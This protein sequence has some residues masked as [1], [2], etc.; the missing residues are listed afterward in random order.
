MHKSLFY[1]TAQFHLQFSSASLL[2]FGCL[3]LRLGAHNAATPMLAQFVGAIVKVRSQRLLQFGQSRAIFSTNQKTLVATSKDRSGNGTS[4]H[5]RRLSSSNTH[6]RIDNGDGQRGTG[7]AAN[8]ASQTRFS[9]N[10]TIRYS[11]LSTQGR[12]KQHD[13]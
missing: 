3:G 10:N 5:R 8:Y 1:L 13:L 12:Q 9:F 2:Q 6:L 4:A 7:L 11:H